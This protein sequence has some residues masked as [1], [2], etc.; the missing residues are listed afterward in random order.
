M[1]APRRR[2]SPHGYL[3][4]D[5]V[6]RLADEMTRERGSAGD[7]PSTQA[8]LSYR[9]LTLFLAYTRLR[10]GEMAALTVAD[11]DLNRRRISVNK[12]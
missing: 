3:T 1:K 9:T 5:Q 7:R 11:V 2:H 8:N 4:H 10:W 12:A 6:E